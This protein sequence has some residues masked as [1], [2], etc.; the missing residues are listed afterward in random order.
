MSKKVKNM[1]EATEVM[2]NGVQAQEVSTQEVKKAHKLN[3]EELEALYQECSQNLNHKVEAVP[4][5]EWEWLSGYIHGVIKET[6]ARKVF[7]DIRLEDG[8]VIKK[9]YSNKALRILPEVVERVTKKRATSSEAKE[10]WTPEEWA[11]KIREFAPAIGSWI[12]VKDGLFGRVI[13]LVPDKRV[14]MLLLRVEVEDLDGHKTYAHKSFN[15]VDWAALSYD[16]K[17]EEMKTN[18]LERYEKR[19]A[20]EPKEKV[21]KIDALK[22]KIAK[23][24]AKLKVMLL[25]LK[26][27]EA[28]EANEPEASE[29]NDEL[30]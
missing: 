8:R 21:S 19:L 16:E 12:E 5:G 7:Y 18:W 13:S 28:K 6:R 27:L 1:S 26:E 24:Q 11:E 30:A 25:E 29:T 10:L 23:A 3:D 9:V 20:A 4:F 22:A 15:Q 17:S 2:N 14:N